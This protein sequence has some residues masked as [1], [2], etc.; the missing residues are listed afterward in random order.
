MT[1]LARPRRIARSGV[2]WVCVCLLVHGE[3]NYY[4]VG[5]RAAW[6]VLE[7]SPFDVFVAVGSTR[8]WRLAA[9]GRLRTLR[10]PPPP[11]PADRAARFLL[12]FRALEACLRTTRAEHLIL[13]D[14]DTLVVRTID[15]DD[16]VAALDGRRLGMVEQTT[17]RRSGMTRAD[18]HRHYRR[19]ALAWLAARGERSASTH[20][21]IADLETFRFFNSGVVL[22]QRAELER[23]AAWALESATRPASSHQIG[24]HMIAD[25]DYLQIWTNHLHPGSC[26]TLPWQWNH[27]E[28]W[29]R[30]FP[31]PHARILHFSNF[32]RGPTLAQVTR[33]E[34]QRRRTGLGR[35]SA[36]VVEGLHRT[37]RRW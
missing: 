28:H 14:A 1:L 9:E 24:A 11:A 13:L 30:G 4:R 3:E 37:L 18:F 8:R 35:V 5:R 7:H 12:K 34:L 15:D 23:I 33:M 10:L 16:V 25:Q 17:I 20:D 32:C 21:P 22:G 26:A 31:R 19:H 6:S 2:G 29:D 36:R 27:C